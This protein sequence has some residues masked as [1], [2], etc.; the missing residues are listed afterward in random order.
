[1]SMTEAINAS[2]SEELS[3][4]KKFIY[5]EEVIEKLESGASSTKD[6]QVQLK[7]CEEE[8]KAITRE[9][10]ALSLFSK[11]ETVSDVPTSS[12]QFLLVPSFLAAVTQG[13]IGSPEERL[14]GLDRAKIYLRDF[15]E[16]LYSY[17]IID[18]PLPWSNQDDDSDERKVKQARRYDPAQRRDEKIRRFQ[19]QKKLQENFEELKAQ[20]MR[21]ID[22]DS[23]L[24]ELLL[25]R[26]RL[27]ANKAMEDLD[28]I[29]E[30]RPLAERMVMVSKGEISPEPR[31]PP[32]QPRRP[33]VL[34][35]DKL[36]KEVFG[37]GYPSVPT[38]TVDE[39]CDEMVKHGRFNEPEKSAERELPDDDDE[40]EE[41]QEIR[42]R[43][44]QNWDEYKDTHRRGWGNTKN[45]G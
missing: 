37:L 31:R 41:A 26:L 15:L 1:M 20:R 2:G 39:W 19:Q 13:L 5:C 36:Q 12:L 8:L 6:L 22:D 43:R 30:E 9:I 16:R 17:E 23:L 32:P 45:K 42:R 35:R 38:K 40:S 33:F 10:S 24:R 44:A 3:L 27:A 14:A 7:R 29:E 11:N 21:N 4:S 28:H 34:T 18:F 25:S